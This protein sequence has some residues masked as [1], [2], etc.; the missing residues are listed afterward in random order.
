MAKKTY[1]VSIQ[2]ALA[3]EEP[4]DDTFDFE[5]EAT[6]DEIEKLQQLFEEPMNYTATVPAELFTSLGPSGEIQERIRN[7]D[8]ALY[9]VY[10]MIYDL[11]SPKTKQFIEENEILKEMMDSHIQ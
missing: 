11:G 2:N 4:L 5:I 6:E 3:A 1:Y 9:K 10:Q 7:Y 8:H